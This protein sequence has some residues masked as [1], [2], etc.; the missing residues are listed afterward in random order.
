[1]AETGKNPSNHA[2]ENPLAIWRCTQQPTLPQHM[3]VPLG[4]STVTVEKV[5]P[6][7]GCQIKF[8][9]PYEIPVACFH[10]HSVF[11]GK[12]HVDQYFPA[13]GPA[14]T[15]QPIPKVTVM[16]TATSV[17]IQLRISPDLFSDL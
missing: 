3:P 10:T 6:S 15:P 1:M 12:G 16:L 2:S 8:L 17:W 4:V 11:E 14:A 13:C 5:V 9:N 7:S